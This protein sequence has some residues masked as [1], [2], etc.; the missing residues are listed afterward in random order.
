MTHEPTPSPEFP[1]F[2]DFQANVTF[3]P[4]QFFTAVLPY[5]SRGTVRPPR[6]RTIVSSTVP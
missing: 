4:L 1:G 3:V 6:K 2:P 5:A